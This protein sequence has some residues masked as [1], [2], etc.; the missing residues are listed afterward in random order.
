MRYVICYDIRSQDRRRRV[1]ECLDGYGDRIQRSVFEAVLDA[2]LFE[3]CLSELMELI[4][5]VEDSIA[6]YALCAACDGRRFY[7]GAAEGRDVGSEKVY[8]V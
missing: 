7:R 8:I 4:D 1:S 6:A 5:P 2:A 3:S